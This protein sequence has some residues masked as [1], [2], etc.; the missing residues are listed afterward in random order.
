[1][2]RKITLVILLVSL[3]ILFAGCAGGGNA[4][5]PESGKPVSKPK[6][7]LALKKK[8]YASSYEKA[9]QYNGNVDLTPDK[10]VDGD[11]STRWGSDHFSDPDPNSAWIYVDL[12]SSMPFQEVIIK[13]EAAFASAFD[14]ETSDDANT[15]TAV[16]SIT[17]NSM[18]NDDIV[19]DKPVTARYV[20]IDCKARHTQ[21]G[22]SI[23]ELEIY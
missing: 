10:A 4:E 3:A 1:M 8:A 18:Q 9:N 21:Y 22:Y 14:I 6:V 11:M 2:L 23:Y 17:G 20:K 5:K 13:W 16:K 12:G 19:L 7:N 15:W